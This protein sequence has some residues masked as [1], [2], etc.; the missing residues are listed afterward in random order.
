[1]AF[2][3]L[4]WANGLRNCGPVRYSNLTLEFLFYRL[5][6]RNIVFDVVIWAVLF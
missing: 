4:L 1:M 3:L 2:S 6:Q 5:L